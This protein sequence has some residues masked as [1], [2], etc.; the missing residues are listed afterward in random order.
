TM[1][2]NTNGQVSSIDGARTDV[3]D[4]TTLSYNVCT[5]GGACGQLSSLTNALGQSTT[6]DSY[7]A[8]GRLLQS[9]DA[10]GL[11]TTYTYDSRGRVLKIT[12]TPT[13]G[14]TRVTTYTYTAAGDVAS[15][16]FPDSRT[17]SYT[18]SAPRKPTR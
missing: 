16:S 6:F 17:L 18:Y 7:D 1:S 13:S 15:V 10:N 12:Q 14:S 11:K 3:S 2:Y 8:N 4:V 5:S 9:T